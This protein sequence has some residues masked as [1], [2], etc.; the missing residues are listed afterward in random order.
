MEFQGVDVPT[1]LARM[2]ELVPEAYR[3]FLEFDQKAFKEGAIPPKT[4]PLIALGIAHI[5]QCP[6]CI[7]AHTRKAVAAGASDQEIGETTFVA[8]AMAAGSAWSH[9]GLM[10][11]CLHEHKG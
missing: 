7:Q 5:T 8:M 1:Q 9:G 6:W 10:L 4:T 11:Q 2:R 3:A